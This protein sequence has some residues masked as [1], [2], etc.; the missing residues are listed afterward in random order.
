MKIADVTIE[1]TTAGVEVEG[2]KYQVVVLD[3]TSAVEGILGKAQSSAFK[4][5]QTHDICNLARVDVVH[6]YKMHGFAEAVILKAAAA[7]ALVARVEGG[8]AD[9]SPTEVVVAVATVA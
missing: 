5:K 1:F 3:I 7:D 9:W 4:A 2:V 6:I 8:S